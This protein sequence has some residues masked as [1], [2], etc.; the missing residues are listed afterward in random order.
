MLYEPS[1]SGDQV[2]LGGVSERQGMIMWGSNANGKL[3]TLGSP[4]RQGSNDF[5]I[6]GDIGGSCSAIIQQPFHNDIYYIADGTPQVQRYIFAASG[7]FNGLSS[8]MQSLRHDF[9]SS[10]SIKEFRVYFPDLTGLGGN[11]DANEKLQLDGYFNGSSSNTVLGTIGS[12]KHDVGYAK[13]PYN[14]SDV[15]SINVGFRYGSDI[16]AGDP[17]ILPYKIEVIYDDTNKR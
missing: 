4:N 16:A 1:S 8:S 7:G 5:N 12:D 15:Y 17:T 10:V 11:G 13:I 2:T 14:K 9:G 6:I 3:Y